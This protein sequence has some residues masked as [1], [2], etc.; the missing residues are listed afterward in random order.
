MEWSIGQM[1]ISKQGRDN[2]T[3]YA[4]MRVEDNFC[5]VADGRKTTY[6]KPKKKNVKHLQATHWVS[7]EIEETLQGGKIPTDA[8]IR[9][10]L[11]KHRSEN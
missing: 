10:F 6:L 4:V 8:E 11:N 3:V 5:F 1:V 9:E 7:A 2:G